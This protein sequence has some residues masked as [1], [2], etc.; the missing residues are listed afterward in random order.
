MAETAQTRAVS[1]GPGA[2]AALGAAF[3]AL[4]AAPFAGKARHPPEVYPEWL[5]V[6]MMAFAACFLAFRC[7]ARDD[8]GRVERL[9]AGIAVGLALLAVVVPLTSYHASYRDYPWI[10][11]GP[12]LFFLLVG[13][14]YCRQR[15]LCLC[16]PGFLLF[17]LHGAAQAPDNTNPLQASSGDPPPHGL[18]V[19][20]VSAA[21]GRPGQPRGG[22]PASAR[23]QRKP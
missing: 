22:E 5:L 23:Q 6:G 1:K 20:L 19:I 12:L 10:A 18:P 3:L 16:L 14:W 2:G 21:L 11:V 15:W 7:S 4:L 8:T 9:T 17:W 13:G